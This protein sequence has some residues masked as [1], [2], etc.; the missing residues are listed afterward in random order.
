M[1]DQYLLDH[2]VIEW[3]DGAPMSD[4]YGDIYWHRDRA[5]EEKQ[6]VFIEPLKRLADGIEPYTQ[7]S[8][9]E[10]GFGFGINC[11]LAAEFWQSMSAHCQLNLVSIEKH[12]VDP[13]S[14]AKLLQPYGFS[15][16]QALLDQ[17]PLP[18][19]GQH[20]IWLA[21]NVRLLL[22]LD[23]VEPALA[24][25]DAE[26]DLWFLDGFSPARND[27]M[28]A[29]KLFRT[30]F[31]RSRLGAQVATYSAAGQVRRNLENS[32][33]TTDKLTGYGEKREMLSASRPGNWQAKPHGRQSTLVI[34]AGLA[35]LYCAEALQ[36]RQTSFS[37]VDSG[38]PGASRIPQLTVL[39]QLAVRPEVRYRFSLCAFQYM[40]DS[41]GFHQTG[42]RWR[43]RTSEEV[44]RLQKI[45][46]GFTDG[47]IEWLPDGDVMFHIA[48]WLSSEA[49]N[50]TLNADI[51]TATVSHIT[52]QDHRWV[53][54]SETGETFRADNL[55]MA[56]GSNRS[57]LDS[58]L[59]VRAIR[60]QAISVGTRD[61]SEI[62]N[63]EVTVFPTVNGRS[64][65]SGTYARQDDME[66]DPAET[67]QLLNSAAALA[68]IETDNIEIHMGI[69]AVSRDRLPVIGQ[70]PVWTDLKTVNRVSA[71]RNFEDG[72][73]LCTAFGSRGATHARLC[74]EHVVSKALGE[75][76]AL[77][78]RQQSMLS[79]ARFQVRDQKSD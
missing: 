27:A 73:Y 25:L 6:H 58:A 38:V 74:A 72:L 11:L 42:L 24:N 79:P 8:V 34:G 66:I 76:A 63:S 53:A 33:F 23:D 70:V 31:A 2:A 60:G 57:M 4:T 9:C 7:V 43:G 55:I 35:G 71:I 64:V 56:T 26:I 14:L 28:W 36:R 47:L 50:A 30:M 46:S 10:L 52:R 22:I 12:P 39:P 3:Q 16:T 20:V 54:S 51:K 18:F 65:V 77:D 67:R 21:P 68:D 69:R 29:H 15:C 1:T 62:I 19:Q 75:P 78:L 32:G 45:A 17:Y 49:L 59:Q 48:G 40:L 61:L 37:M 13:G 44:E 5:V 41:P